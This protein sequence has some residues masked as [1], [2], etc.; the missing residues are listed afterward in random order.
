MLKASCENRLLEQPFSTASLAC[1]ESLAVN[2][3]G[4]SVLL[5]SNNVDSLKWQPLFVRLYL[6]IMAGI[7][8]EIPKEFSLIKSFDLLIVIVKYVNGL[9][10]KQW[11]ALIAEIEEDGSGLSNE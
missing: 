8:D 7:A 3:E 5:T 4:S 6:K 9:E 11:D 10:I 2:S 1:S